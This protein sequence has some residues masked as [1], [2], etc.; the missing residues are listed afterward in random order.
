MEGSHI[1]TD[2]GTMTS[3]VNIHRLSL[4]DPLVQEEWHKSPTPASFLPNGANAPRYSYESPLQIQTY[5][6]VMRVQGY[7]GRCTTHTA[8]VCV[9]VDKEAETAR[10]IDQSDW[11]KRK[12][13]P[14]RCLCCSPD[15]LTSWS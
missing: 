14:V 15:P 1:D 4:A 9:A 6:T 7:P 5:P 10:R 12:R 11:P 3:G 8:P 2:N 13:Y